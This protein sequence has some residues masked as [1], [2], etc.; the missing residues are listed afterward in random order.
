MKAYKKVKVDQELMLFAKQENEDYQLICSL[1]SDKSARHFLKTHAIITSKS[2]KNKISRQQL[3]QHYFLPRMMQEIHSKRKESVIINGQA[4][5]DSK[6]RQ[7]LARHGPFP[8]V[9][10]LNLKDNDI[11]GLATVAELFPH[12]RTLLLSNPCPMQM[13]TN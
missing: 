4:I 10:K 8:H 12:T 1:N 2:S 6:L 9:N 3:Q 13:L 5:S 7:F 11:G